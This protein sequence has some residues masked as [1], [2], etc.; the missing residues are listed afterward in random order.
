MKGGTLY[1]SVVY[2]SWGSYGEAKGA[3]AALP[4]PLAGLQPWVR[5]VGLIHK[6]MR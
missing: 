5:K 3:L 6:E 1:F 4:A 2:G